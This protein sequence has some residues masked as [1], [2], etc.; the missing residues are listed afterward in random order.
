MSKICLKHVYYVFW[1]FAPKSMF[2]VFTP[3]NMF[4]VFAP[5]AKDHVPGVHAKEHVP[6]VR[7]CSRSSRSPQ[8]ANPTQTPPPPP[9]ETS[10]LDLHTFFGRYFCY[11]DNI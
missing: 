4:R 6:G 8:V 1:V 10:E 5:R 9:V 11:E 3:K 7:T 2:W